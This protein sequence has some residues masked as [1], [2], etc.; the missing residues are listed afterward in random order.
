MC[1]P[2]KNETFQISCMDDYGRVLQFSHSY[3][4][5]EEKSDQIVTIVNFG[6]I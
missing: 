4:L 3:G 1:I 6:E 5:T 2:Y